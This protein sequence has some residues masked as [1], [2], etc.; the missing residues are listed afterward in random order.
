MQDLDDAQA[1]LRLLQEAVLGAYGAL[2]TD[3]GGGSA[4]AQAH[5][6]KLHART[7]W[8]D[9]DLYRR[10]VAHGLKPLAR[11]F[12]LGAAQLGSLMH[13][14]E[15]GLPPTPNLMPEALAAK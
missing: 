15:F 6:R 4:A 2:P 8:L 11:A 7:P 14:Q 5:R 1:Y 3:G 10:A 13:H 9:L 12:M